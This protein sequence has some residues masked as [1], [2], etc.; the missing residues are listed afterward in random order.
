MV[1]RAAI[2]VLLG[3]LGL[4]S[5]L[6][7]VAGIAGCGLER[8]GLDFRI[9]DD[10]TSTSGTH[11]ANR[12]SSSISRPSSGSTSSAGSASSTQATSG[13]SSS[14]GSVASDGGSV[15]DAGSANVDATTDA[16][17]SDSGVDPCNGGWVG[18]PSDGGNS[19]TTEGVFFGRVVFSIGAGN[20]VT[21]LHTT[22]T[23]PDEPPAMGSLE[24][25]PSL[26]PNPLS[27]AP[28]LAD[29]GTVQPTLA[30]GPTCLPSSPNN[31]YAAWSASGD[32]IDNALAS[33]VCQGGDGMDVKVGDDLAI[34][35]ALQGT[36]WNESIT[37]SRNGRT[38][39]FDIDV[40]GQP[41]VFPTFEIASNAQSPVSDIVFTSTTITMA[42]SEP[43]ACQPTLRGPDDSFSTPTAS[44]DGRTCCI[45]HVVLRA[46]G[47][48]ATTS[49]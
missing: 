1:V 46:L 18:V 45:S 20:G 5:T 40:E 6:G 43:G 31:A 10:T 17:S 37:N 34:D 3:G 39:T 13:G 38:V 41:E 33:S 35:L 24:V 21:G 47:V 48:P 25:F 28:N 9:G 4:S 12:S 15:E 36:G 26:A 22:L 14:G 23:V 11:T 32:Y 16:A 19:S 44:L 42:A 7:M 2:R 30:W 27:P 29:L 49:F 8:N